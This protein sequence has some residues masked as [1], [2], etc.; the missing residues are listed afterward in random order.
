MSFETN[1]KKYLNGPRD[2]KRIAE[3][4]SAHVNRDPL[5]SY[6]DAPQTDL[7]HFQNLKS[8]IMAWPIGS[9]EIIPQIS[10][11]HQ[12][13]LHDSVFLLL[14]GI[15][16]FTSSIYE[17]LAGFPSW[18]TSSAYHAAYF[19]MKSAVAVLGVVATSSAG[20]EIVV[21][22]WPSHSKGKSKKK[23][24]RMGEM[25]NKT[26][27]HASSRVSQSQ[28]WQMCIQVLRSSDFNHLDVPARDAT[29]CLIGHGYEGISRSRNS[30]HYETS[31]WPHNDIPYDWVFDPEELQRATLDMMMSAPAAD[32]PSDMTF[33][34]WLAYTM[35]I[36]TSSLYRSMSVSASAL[37]PLCAYLD[38]THNRWR[39]LLMQ[40][41]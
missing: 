20:R 4:W 40:G 30:I 2:W 8:E 3:D 6:F 5:F 34:L 32:A 28:Y 1:L 22:V 18:A 39:S 19:M 16:V 29:E 11:L 14:K 26:R 31:S 24:K 37:L 36:M 25:E 33:S 27:I 13:V 12:A 38:A 7:G 41:I 15:N 23:I 10:G 21:D 9:G 35:F 17:I